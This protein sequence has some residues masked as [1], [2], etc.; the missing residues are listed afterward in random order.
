MTEGLSDLELNQ[1]LRK[2][3]ALL[4]KYL[5]ADYK[6]AL[7][8]LYK[9][10]PELNTGYTSLVLPDFV[11]MYGKAEPD[12]SLE[13]LKYFT[14]FGSSEFAVR[15][16]LKTD[17][18]KTLKVM[19]EWA[20]DD[21]YHVRRLASEGSR[22]RLPW[23]FKL[24]SIIREPQL[25]RSI[26]ERLKADEVLYVRKS[27]ANHLN[28]L[29]RENADYML[30]LIKGWDTTNQHTAWIVKHACRTLIKKGHEGSLAFFKYEKNVKIDVSELKLKKSV[31]SLGDALD[32]EF[33]VVSRKST[34]QKL[35]VDYAIHYAKA[36]GAISR[37]VFKI[38]QVDLQP[39]EQVTIM[40]KQTFNDFTTRKH[41][42]GKHLIEILI[43]GKKVTEAGF[44]LR[45]G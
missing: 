37:K 20:K 6:K 41:Y 32:F 28:D 8:V 40:K 9:V 19:N 3:S 1:R 33:T 38:K 5:P 25:T 35:V 10:A 43:N 36:T 29:S 30:G 15:E 24:D 42:A 2:T 23:S 17:L 21:D 18:V 45:V 22:P 44:R 14:K 13:A 26:L 34:V 4:R 16:F 7:K 39:G 12:V 11:G 31:I 27:V